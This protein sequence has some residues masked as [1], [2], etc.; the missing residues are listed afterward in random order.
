MVP[1]APDF[2]G[3]NA[4][5]VRP[6]PE[7]VESAPEIEAW[8]PAEI[9]ARPVVDVD[10]IDGGQH[11]PAALTKQLFVVGK[12]APN[13]CRC[14]GAQM[15]QVASPEW[16]R[17][18]D[19][20]SREA[21]FRRASSRENVRID[22]IS[23]IEPAIQVFVDLEI[24]IVVLPPGFRIIV[25]FRKEPRR[26][27]DDAGQIVR[28]EEQLAQIFGRLL[29]HPVDVP[30][31]RRRLLI[32]PGGGLA[33]GRSQRAAEGTGRAAVNDSGDSALQRHLEKSQR[34]GDV[35]L[36][37]CMPRVRGDV[38]FVERGGVDDAI[39][40]AHATPEEIAIGNRTDMARERGLQQVEADDLVPAGTQGADEP[41]T[42]VS[43]AS[44]H[45]NA[46]VVVPWGE[47][48]T[49]SAASSDAPCSKHC[50]GGLSGMQRRVFRLRQGSGGLAEALN[51]AAD[52]SAVSGSRR[53][54]QVFCPTCRG[55]FAGASNPEAVDRHSTI[56]NCEACT[57]NGLNSPVRPNLSE[58]VTVNRTIPTG[59]SGGTTHL[60]TQN[61]R[62]GCFSVA[63]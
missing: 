35:G 40:A 50:S 53:Q 59:V 41:L 56:V 21:D 34:S 58:A 42:E 37:E 33:A 44:S 1:L 27:E 48:T 20:V 13:D 38:R 49:C 5:H 39:D 30:R 60:A 45:E 57:S 26:A 61:S 11:A 54:R 28:L 43:R 23:E 24:E 47:S 18:A 31:N 46:H 10:T 2:P 55:G 63:R 52:G 51:A 3:K 6:V 12:Q 25:R 7:T 32:D 36:D 16:A 29:G 9:A 15:R 22:G 4:E 19:D 8:L 62:S 17:G 14:I